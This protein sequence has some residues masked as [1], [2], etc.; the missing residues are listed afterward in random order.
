[1]F[2]RC[3]GLGGCGWNL[4]IPALAGMMLKDKGGEW[5]TL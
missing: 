1:M 5:R 4:W 2:S 3:A